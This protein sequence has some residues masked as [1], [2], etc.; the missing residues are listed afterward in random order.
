MSLLLV[1]GGNS[2]LQS[3]SAF[4]RDDLRLQV[5]VSSSPHAAVKW[6]QSPEWPPPDLLLADISGQSVNGAVNFLAAVRCSLPDQPI[7]ILANNQQ[8]AEAEQFIRA[9]VLDI[10]T[11]P[12]QPLRLRLSVG[13]ALR[14]GSMRQEMQRLRMEEVREKGFGTIIARSR[15]MQQAL[16]DAKN[17]AQHNRPLWLQGEHGTGREMLARAILNESANAGG[18]FVMVH[19]GD[20]RDEA[21]EQALFGAGPR[22][23]GALQQAAHG[24]LYLNEVECLPP[25]M[26]AMISQWVK[27][28][29]GQEMASRHIPPL[30]IVAATRICTPNITV[31]APGHA[32]EMQRI[33]AHHWCLTPLALP[34]LRE[35][36]EDI[37]EI[38]VRHLRHYARM[39]G[40]NTPA[41]DAQASEWLLN[42]RWP[43][44][45]PEMSRCLHQAL[46]QAEGEDIR[47][48]HLE[49]SSRREQANENRPVTT[50]PTGEHC[51]DLLQDDGALRP[52]AELEDEVVNYAVRHH[53]GC[54]ARVARDLGIGR[55]TLYR[56]LQQLQR[57][58]VVA[59]APLRKGAV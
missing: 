11:L 58:E 31:S 9:G 28:G 17:A 20:M 19:C 27:I 43:G 1:C 24:M 34:A 30:R 23:S 50:N 13:N 52:L 45:L 8:L 5:H 46:W 47:V 26:M 33:L 6:L 16:A 41:L 10:L 32:Q 36:R 22:A 59:A 44:N 55:S 2:P 3:L 51:I 18:P 15:A 14:T 38:A 56:K 39:E 37:L 4:L 40:Y 21:L 25:R 42:H 7:I 12:L 29:A 54:M 49:R 48:E 57:P 53:R 35:R